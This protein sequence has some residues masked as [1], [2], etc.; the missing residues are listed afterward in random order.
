MA[1]SPPHAARAAAPASRL[2]EEA[3]THAGD[4][5]LFS[6]LAATAG[7]FIVLMGLADAFLTILHPDR[8]GRLSAALNRGV[9][10]LAVA[11]ARLRPGSRQ[12]LLGMA[13]PSMVVA[14]ILLWML[15]PILGYALMY[16][17]FLS[18][19]FETPPRLGTDFWDAFYFSGVTFTTLGFGDI[20]P[21]TRIWELLSIAE[22]ITG[23]LVMS[24]SIAYIVA[25]FEGV[26]QRDALALQVFSETAGTWDGARLLTRSLQEEDAQ[27]LRNRL[28]RWA[29]L[30]RELHGRLYRFHGLALYVRTHGL[31]HGPERMLYALADVALGA[32]VLACSPSMRLLRP[33]SDH[34][35]LGFE[36]FAH[37]I[38]RR[39]GTREARRLMAH[40]EP[41]EEDA[42]AV[43]DAWRDL[44]T[45]LD[46]EP[47]PTPPEQDERLLRLAARLRVF[48]AESDRL[49][50]WRTLR[51]GPAARP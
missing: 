34:L 50:L 37:A 49:T 28:E 14:D 42:R 20:T 6:T 19:G 9:W 48:L 47:P 45:R 10:R 46:L 1:A 4:V 5:A 12:E 3:G 7:A 16:W 35:A 2:V 32:K 27:A 31:E 36:H 44:A 51:A 24:T 39:H 38:V 30:V 41:T 17:P 23:F 8:D 26:D 22:A 29:S 21:L 15:L 18:G 13:G 40:P 25:V 33:A 43:R 11:A